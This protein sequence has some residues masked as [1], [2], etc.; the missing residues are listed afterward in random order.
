MATVLIPVPLR[1]LTNTA[2]TV[3]SDGSSIQE[4]IENLEFG[5]PGFRERLCTS[6]GQIRQFINIY[7]NGEDIRFSSGLATP[8]KDTDEVSIVPAMA[9]G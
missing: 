4:L 2:D 5:Y 7:V 3:H 8:L 1:K 9:G 6:D